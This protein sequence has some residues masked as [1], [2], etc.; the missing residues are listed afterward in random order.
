MIDNCIPDGTAI[1][2]Q[3]FIIKQATIDDLVAVTDILAKL[4]D[5][6]DY[7]ELLEENKSHLTKDTQIIL[8]ASDAGTTVGAV[9]ASIRREYVEG[10]I[11]DLPI[12]YLEGIYV[13]PEYR[14]KGIVR[15][16]TEECQ[17]WAKSRG[18]SCF[19]S[20][21]ELDNTE[22]LKFHI[23]TGFQEISRNIHFI[24]ML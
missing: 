17:S 22:S 4:Y 12:G 19:A 2:N 21:C 6:H 10:R 15:K 8:L 20:D 9:H 11:D 3:G 7:N 24:K 14:L 1:K 13:E 23:R 16:L 5:E 18:C